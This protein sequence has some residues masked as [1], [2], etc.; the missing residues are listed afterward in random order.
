MIKVGY[1]DTLN[2]LRKFQEEV[3]RKLKNMIAGFAY[4]VTLIASANTPEGNEADLLAGKF[5]KGSPAQRKY[6][7]FYE[8]RKEDYGIDTETGFHKGAWFYSESLSKAL[9]SAIRPGE[10]AASDAYGDALQSYRLGDRFYILGVGPAFTSLEKG[11]STQ[12][13]GGII[14]PSMNQIMQTYQINLQKYYREG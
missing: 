3:E 11:K 1:Q 12:A 4:E 5:G 7:Q 13:P 14:G 2:D 6:Y 10:H 9:D 8:S